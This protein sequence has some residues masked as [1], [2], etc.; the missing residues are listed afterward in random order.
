MTDIN[1]I[2]G[3]KVRHRYGKHETG[4]IMKPIRWS[5][6]HMTAVIRVRLDLKFG[7]GTAAFRLGQLEL[8]KEA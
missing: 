8:I 4:I 6:R 7:G 2:P 1:F 5:W 3:K